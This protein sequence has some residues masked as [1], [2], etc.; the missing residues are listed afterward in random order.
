MALCPARI[1]SWSHLFEQLHE[2]HPQCS[3][4][5]TFSI[6]M[7]GVIAGSS[8][9]LFILLYVNDQCLCPIW[10]LTSNMKEL[11]FH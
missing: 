10:C 1:A 5:V 6:L 8:N 2:H 4:Q 11:K 3:G 7:G 9:Q